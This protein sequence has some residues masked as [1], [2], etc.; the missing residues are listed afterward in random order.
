[1]AISAYIN[2]TPQ[3]PNHGDT[4]TVNYVVTGNDP[5]AP[6]SAMI[7]GHVT[8]GG[9]GYDVNTSITLPGTPAADVSYDV[10]TCPGLTFAVDPADPDTFT[11]VVP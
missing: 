6:S 9:V 7:S 2:A 11:A 5:T 3:A 4:I 1:M 10:P 8:V